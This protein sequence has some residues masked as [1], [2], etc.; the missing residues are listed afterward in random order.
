MRTRRECLGIF[1]LSI[2]LSRYLA[3]HLVTPI[4]TAV[5]KGYDLRLVDYVSPTISRRF[6]YFL[7]FFYSLSVSILV[8][9][10]NITTLDF[11]FLF[12]TSHASAAQRNSFHLPNT[13]VLLTG[14][15]Q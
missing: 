1:L 5:G 12:T 7:F 3:C 11:L 9:V 6:L 13:A 4:Q 10:C 8:K 15:V 14:I 2:C